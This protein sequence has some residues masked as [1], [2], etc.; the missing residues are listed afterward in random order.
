ML[1]LLP[2]VICLA[3]IQTAIQI[4]ATRAANTAVAQ[5]TAEHGTVQV[6]HFS[7]YKPL[8][9]HCHATRE[10]S[11]SPIQIT[12]NFP[13]K[14]LPASHTNYCQLP[15]QITASLPYRSL[16]TSQPNHCQPPIQ[17]TTHLASLPSQPL[18]GLVTF[19]DVIGGS[20]GVTV[21]VSLCYV[22]AT[23]PPTSGELSTVICLGGW[24]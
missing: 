24:Q 20:G 3:A 10:G 7:P 1:R 18:Q 5:F 22:D 17:I 16:P 12:A 13:A 14:S 6:T 11:H 9:N 15:S 19:S 2:T 4:T 23:Q 8:P 21:S